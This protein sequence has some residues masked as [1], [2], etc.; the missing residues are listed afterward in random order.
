M[1]FSNPCL[2]TSCVSATFSFVGEFFSVWVLDLPIFLV[3]NGLVYRRPYTCMVYIVE[4]NVI[5]SSAMY[6]HGLY[7]RTERGVT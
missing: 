2:V 5:V 6:L 7:H 3:L 4:L 1:L